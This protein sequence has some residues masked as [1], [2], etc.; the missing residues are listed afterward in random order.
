MV[1]KTVELTEEQ[2]ERL[3]A[4]R[5]R[6]YQQSQGPDPTALYDLYQR[7]RLLLEELESEERE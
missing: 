3:R 4:L 7:M 6:V 5:D 1:T 2:V